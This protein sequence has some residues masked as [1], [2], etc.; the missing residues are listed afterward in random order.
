MGFLDDIIASAKSVVGKAEEQ[1]EVFLQH[2]APGIVGR[3]VGSARVDAFPQRGVGIIRCRLIDDARN[4]TEGEGRVYA[5]ATTVAPAAQP[6]EKAG[7]KTVFAVHCGLF[8]RKN[9]HAQ[10]SLCKK[11]GDIRSANG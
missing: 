10:A 11:K 1:P 3:S 7:R 8:S 4:Q 2:P 5:I 6:A 9:A